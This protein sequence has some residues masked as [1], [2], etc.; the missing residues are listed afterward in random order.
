MDTRRSASAPGR[1]RGA[2]RALEEAHLPP[3]DDDAVTPPP[4]ARAAPDL[5]ALLSALQPLA[6]LPAVLQRLGGPSSGTQPDLATRVADHLARS[7]RERLQ[8]WRSTLA[9]I[10][11]AINALQ[12][13]TTEDLRSLFAEQ[14]K[15]QGFAPVVAALL[16]ALLFLDGPKQRIF[17][18]AVLKHPAAEALQ[19][20]NVLVADA[21][22]VE[23][24]GRS[25][26]QLQTPLWPDGSQFAAL[27]L[28]QFSTAGGSGP[29][30]GSSPPSL[31][32]G[33]A[34]PHLHGTAFTSTAGGFGVAAA[35]TTTT[36]TTVASDNNDRI[37]RLEDRLVRLERRGPPSA[38]QPQQPPQQQPQQHQLAPESRGSH[39]R[40]GGGETRGRGRTAGAGPVPPPAVPVPDDDEWGGAGFSL[41]PQ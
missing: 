26:V 2:S 23:E 11:S 29:A 25:L 16:T 15:A 9:L 10:D 13:S 32:R 36:T 12:R 5:D 38:P 34:P 28:A 27:R 7:E 21:S 6:V 37:K 22:L 33:F 41:V 40:G 8:P 20:F 31:P 18:A 24:R 35:G 17:A 14:A 19:V 3:S 4:A 30:G 39:R 1:G